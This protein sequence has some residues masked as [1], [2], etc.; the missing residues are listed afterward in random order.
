[1]TP[2]WQ[3][4]LEELR[5]SWLNPQFFTSE[6]KRILSKM[7]VEA[8]RIIVYNSPAFPNCWVLIEANFT[9]ELWYLI[10][11]ANPKKGSI[12]GYKAVMNVATWVSVLKAAGGETTLIKSKKEE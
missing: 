1:M 11:S 6:V 8:K 10:E 3:A 4:E 2:K 7:N 12:K 9:P 5:K